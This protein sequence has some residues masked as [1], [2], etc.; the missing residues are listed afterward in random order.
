MS[1]PLPP[2]R[3]RGA[4]RGPERWACNSP[5]LVAINGTVSSDTCRR[6]PWPDHSVEGTTAPSH[7]VPQDRSAPREADSGRRPQPPPQVGPRELE[8]DRRARTWS[9]GLTTAPRKTETLRRT[10]KSLASAGWP[11]PRVFADGRVRVPGGYAV[12]R[13]KP[14]IGAWPNWHLGLAELM[15]RQ[16]QADF[17]AMVQDDVL[18]CR[19]LRDYLEEAHWPHDAGVI[20]VFCPKIYN[21]KPGLNRIRAGFGLAGAQTLIFCREAAYDLMG[22]PWI[23]NYRR[24]PPQARHFRSDGLSHI[25][26]V[27]GKWAQLNNW[28]VYFHSPSLAKHIG[29]DSVMYPGFKGKPNSRWEDSFVGE[30]FDARSLLFENRHA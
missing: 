2:C 22:D 10:L 11:R 8:P 15:A 17:Y 9:L 26:G 7:T 19:H 25:D 28:G 16:P 18:F 3:H 5:K 1:E 14:A 13:R 4:A 24:R 23:A 20:S 30:P 12:T 21:N 27:V 6:C 29:F